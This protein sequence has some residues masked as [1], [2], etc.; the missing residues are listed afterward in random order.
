[1]IAPPGALEISLLFTNFSTEALND[2]VR[3]L[4]CKD[5]SCSQ[6]KQLAELSG[7]YANRQVVVSA[8]GYMM[9]VF[10]SDSSNNSDG[11]TASWSS[12]SRILLKTV[13]L[14]IDI[15]L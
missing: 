12:V 7:L 10:S 11:F 2:I 15:C 14:K 8:T 9:V 4:E 5:Y 1:M 13:V 3:V 6:R